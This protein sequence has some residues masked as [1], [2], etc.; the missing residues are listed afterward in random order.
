LLVCGAAATLPPRLGAQA[1]SPAAA[2][3]SAR[4][5]IGHAAEIENYLRTVP[6]LK[7][8][9]LSV[10]V[11]HPRKAT[12]PPGGPMQYLAWKVIPP[13][14]YEG[15]WESY[16]SEI[17]A[18]E[19]DKLL[20]LNMVPPTV[21]REYHSDRGAAVMWCSPTKSFK[22]LGGKGAP[23][24]PPAYAASWAR[25]IARAKMFDNLINNLDPNLGNWLVD[26]AW[27]LILIDHTRA[28]T[29]GLNMIHQMTHIDAELWAR[30][31]GLTEA[32]IQAPLGKWI[33]R[34]EAKSLIARR[35]KMQQII[36]G[37][38]KANGEA[39]VFIKGR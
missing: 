5:W 28:F 33:M 7:L 31:Q 38:V 29:P 20:E 1:P 21:E 8:Q 34:G 11:T 19:M 9:D 23:E 2:P 10:G 27:D 12:L 25:Q 35:D 26:P 4:T 22:E 6:I 17:A 3:V 30:M 14:R 16:L 18:Y 36:D 15:F 24:A 37:L 39:A 32:S 13:A